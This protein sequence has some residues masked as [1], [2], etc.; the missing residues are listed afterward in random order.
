MAEVVGRSA[1]ARHRRRRQRREDR[2]WVALAG[3]VT[4]RRIGEAA[5]EP[6]RGPAY[7][8]APQSTPFFTRVIDCGCDSGMQGLI[9]KRC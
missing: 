4:T 5:D 2:T 6:A 3:P 1:G 8:P 7:E 9:L